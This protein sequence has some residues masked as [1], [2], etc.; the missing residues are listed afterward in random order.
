VTAVS[1]PGLLDSKCSEPVDIM[2]H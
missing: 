1:N 2:V